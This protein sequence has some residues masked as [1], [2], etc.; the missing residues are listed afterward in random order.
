[1]DLLAGILASLLHLNLKGKI[2]QKQPYASALGGSCDV[3]TAWS[4][5]HKKKVAVKQIRIFLK[6]DPYL[7]KRLAKEI[8][9]WSKLEHKNIVPLLGYFVEGRGRMPSLVSEWMEKGTL[10]DFM[11]LLPRGGSATSI[12]LRGV[13]S[14]LEYLHSKEIIHADLKTQ[15]ILISASERPLLA[16]F[17]LSLAL[18][19]SQNTFDTPSALT[20]G[21]M[22]WMA[23]ELLPSLS[24]GEPSK[25]D[26]KSDIWAFGMVIYKLLSWSVPYYDKQSDVLVLLAIING[27]L[28]EMPIAPEGGC[29]HIFH[30][31]WELASSCWKKRSASRPTAEYLTNR[32]NDNLFVSPQ[33]KLMKRVVRKCRRSQSVP[34]LE[35]EYSKASQFM[36]PILPDTSLHSDS[37]SNIRSPRS[38]FTSSS[39]QSNKLPK[40]AVHRRSKSLDARAQDR[41]L[42]SQAFLPTT[43][44]C[45]NTLQ[46][47][48]FAAIELQQDTESEID[49]DYDTAEFLLRYKA[50][51]LPPT[52]NFIAGDNEPASEIDGS[53]DF[54]RERQTEYFTEAVNNE[55]GLNLH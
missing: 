39:S 47:Q 32:L 9:I 11:K 52:T 22:R 53:R 31:L 42:R 41:S 15:N 13:A 43:D 2:I 20:K 24:G 7:A 29:K 44:Y 6:K 30:S 49:I 54:E 16:D 46:P 27:Q 45:Q 4:V 48:P 14:G 36:R 38:M 33:K 18:S 21:T 51:F 37:N 17:G 34:L 23:V 35:A 8:R 10:F 50:P 40:F 55:Y 12:I 19:H 26:K 28:P 25:N 5:K 3:Y 1:M